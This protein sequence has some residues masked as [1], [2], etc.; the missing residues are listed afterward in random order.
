[1]SKQDYIDHVVG[2]LPYWF[3]KNPRAMENIEAFAEIFCRAE[4]QSVFFQQ[5]T[6][7]EQATDG[8]PD[9]LNQHAIDRS[10]L[11]QGGES[12]PSLRQRIRSFDKVLSYEAI[13][14]YVQSVT[15]A[16]GLAGTATLLEVKQNKAF[17]VTH[18]DQLGVGGVFTDLGSGEFAFEPSTGVSLDSTINPNAL[19]KYLEIAVASSAGNTGIFEVTGA[20]ASG[21]KYGN[22]VGVA[23]TDSFASW[24]LFDRD[25]D[26]EDI[27]TYDDAFYYDPATIGANQAAYRMSGEKQTLV[28]MLPFGCTQ[29]L[30]SSIND[31]LILIKGAGTEILIECRIVP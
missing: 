15:L 12:N 28:I 24:R 10:L 9:W 4:E 30:V 14:A 25:L 2:S 27:T 29:A 3:V 16:S 13:L 21:P 17:F 5:M 8:P 23:E 1:M 18:T 11:R 19:P 7:I 26:L 22:L 6:F 31:G 20:Y